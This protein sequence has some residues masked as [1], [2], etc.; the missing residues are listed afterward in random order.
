MEAKKHFTGVPMAHG[1]MNQKWCGNTLGDESFGLELCLNL[2]FRNCTLIIVY[3]PGLEAYEMA[4]LGYGK[5]NLQWPL[6]SYLI[7]AF[8]FFVAKD[9]SIHR[10]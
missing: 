10:V 5:D 1:F 9:K 7:L 3:L 2:L 8:H 4:S 6:S